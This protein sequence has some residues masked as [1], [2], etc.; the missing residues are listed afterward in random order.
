MD[1]SERGANAHLQRRN[2]LVRQLMAPPSE[3]G[4][5]LDPERVS[6]TVRKAEKSVCE[7]LYK[8]R[9]GPDEVD[10]KMFDLFVWHQIYKHALKQDFPWTADIRACIGKGVDIPSS[11]YAAYYEEVESLRQTFAAMQLEKGM[12]QT[13]TLPAPQPQPQTVSKGPAATSAS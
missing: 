7:K 4:L 8:R 9:I 13:P 1:T 10:H 6:E 3:G 12:E 11:K 5:G 2:Q